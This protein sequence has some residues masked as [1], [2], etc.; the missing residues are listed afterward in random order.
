MDDEAIDGVIG[1]CG[2]GRL[3]FEEGL[4]S[5]TLLPLIG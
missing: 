4:E 3:S 2:S 5:P 1:H